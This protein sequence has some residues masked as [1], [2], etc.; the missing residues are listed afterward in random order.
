MTQGDFSYPSLVLPFV[1][2]QPEHG[3]RVAQVAYRP[4][5][6]ATLQLGS[7]GGTGRHGEAAGAVNSSALHIGRAV[8][9][10]DH[11]LWCDWLAQQSLV[12]RESYW[13]QR[14]SVR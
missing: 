1:E 10:D 9:D 6:A 14:I 13:Q 12:L 3:L 5:R 4:T 11:L 2:E 8:T 7:V